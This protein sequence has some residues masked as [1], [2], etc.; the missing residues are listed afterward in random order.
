MCTVVH[1]IDLKR[2]GST[3]DFMAE[4]RQGDVFHKVAFTISPSTETTP[5]IAITNI[6][7]PPVGHLHD[8]VSHPPPHTHTHTHMHTHTHTHNFTVTVYI[9]PSAV[10]LPFLLTCWPPA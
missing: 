4:T 6:R 1:T 9:G 5:H 3:S 7:R 8:L 2:S 10:A